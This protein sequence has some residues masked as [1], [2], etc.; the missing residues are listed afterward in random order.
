MCVCVG[1]L[2]IRHGDTQR[3][4]LK[5]F[6]SLVSSFDSRIDFLGKL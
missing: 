4:V 1:G 6:T 2:F 3:Q 5:Y